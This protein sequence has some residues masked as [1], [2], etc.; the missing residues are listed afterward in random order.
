M[1]PLET[2]S[3]EE[4]DQQVR[5]CLSHLYDL[6]FLR[7]HPLVQYLVPNATG[8]S[9][10]QM[11]RQIVTE[12]IERLRP[13]AGASYHSKQARSYNLLILRYVE[14]QQ[15]QEVMIQLALS[16]RQFY[17]DHPK[18]IQILS[19]LLWEKI[20][21]I[22]APEISRDFSV[23][24]EVQRVYNQIE[25]HPIDLNALLDGVILATQSLAH[26]HTVELELGLT[27]SFLIRSVNSAALRQLVLL[28]LSQVILHC[29]SGARITLGCENK[30]RSCALFMAIQDAHTTQLEQTL[31]EALTGSKS[32]QTLLEATEGKLNLE[33]VE[34]EIRVWIELPLNQ[35]VVLLV[36]DNPG[37]LDLFQ[38]YLAG[39]AYRVIAV[40]DGTQA[41]QMARQL[42]PNVIILD[43]MLPGMDGWEVLQNL[44]T[45]PVTQAIPVLICTVLDAAD[46]ALSLGADMYMPKPPSQSDFL[47]AL[48]RW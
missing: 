39:Q 11:F 2:I 36:D 20:T 29:P 35:A 31:S 34:A 41:I 48:A 6:S 22:A 21:G 10:V 4:F 17:R 19:S 9:R 14:Q 1:L 18:A 47:K 25:H 40:G 44:K 24:S 7:D 15:P 46:L 32:L 38:R 37:M 26:Q 45:H 33:S 3:V 23:E 8:A 30:P 42:H 43:V 12:A 28:S 13:D 27:G 16:E 5:D